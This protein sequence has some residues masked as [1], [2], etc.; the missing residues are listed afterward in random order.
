[1]NFSI[2]ISFY[3]VLILFFFFPPFPYPTEPALFSPTFPIHPFTP[4]Y[5]QDINGVM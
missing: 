3:C 5:L 1:M 2:Q 4:A